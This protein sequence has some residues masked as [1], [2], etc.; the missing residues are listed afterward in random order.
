MPGKRD[1]VLVKILLSVNRNYSIMN[2]KIIETN[3]GD[4]NSN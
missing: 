2:D 1:T 4:Y 3:I